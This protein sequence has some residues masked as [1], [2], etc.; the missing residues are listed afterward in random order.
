MYFLLFKGRSND[1]VGV[2]R[3]T[4]VQALR[5]GAG[6][7]TGDFAKEKLGGAI[8]ERLL[9]NRAGHGPALVGRPGGWSGTGRACPTNTSCN[10]LRSGPAHQ[11]FKGLGPARPGPLMFRAMGGGPARPGPSI[12]RGPSGFL[13]TRPGPNRTTGP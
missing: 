12:D 3:G 1:D 6:F 5:S 4:V 2:A 10:G 7:K 8:V 11:I 9:R 13:R